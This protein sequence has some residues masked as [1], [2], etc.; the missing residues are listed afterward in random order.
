MVLYGQCDSKMNLMVKFK[1]QIRNNMGFG[2]GCNYNLM[3]EGLG[4]SIK[5]SYSVSNIPFFF[6]VTI[7]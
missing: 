2:F 4:G 6:D 5:S 7:G 1:T 3:N